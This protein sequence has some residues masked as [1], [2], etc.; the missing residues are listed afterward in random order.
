LDLSQVVVQA[1]EALFIEAAVVIEP[2]GDVL[3]RSRFESSRQ[4][5]HCASRQ[6]AIRP[7]LS[8]T[9]RCLEIVGRHRSKGSTS[10]VT[11]ASSEERRVRI[12]RRMGSARVVKVVLRCS[13]VII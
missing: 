7:T 11:D 13:G 3:E 5:R 2:F 1:I 6:R 8:S 10:L 9:L 12:A 4:G